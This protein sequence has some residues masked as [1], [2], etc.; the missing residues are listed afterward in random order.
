MIPELYRTMFLIRTF[1]EL[2]GRLFRQ[3]LLF[4]T[5]HACIGQEAVAAGL[6]A[7]LGPEDMVLS[8]HRG[9][10]HFLAV[11]DDL[12]GL[13]LEIMGREGGVCGGR[14]GSQHLRAPRFYSNGVQ[15]GMVPV[16]A[17][18]ALAEKLR[19]GKGLTVCFIGDGTLGQGVV[20]ETLNLASL[21]GLPLVFA[22]ENNQYAMST[23]VRDALAGSILMRGEAFGVPSA[24]C[25]GNDA[26]QVAAFANEH[27]S[28]LRECPGPMVMVFDTYRLCGHSKS[29][30]CAYRARE[31]E[32]R[33][34]RRDPLAQLE[35]RLDAGAAA[36][37]RA[38]VGAR[39]DQALARAIKAPEAC[40]SVGGHHAR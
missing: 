37:I 21:W 17:G 12:D 1:E 7:A 33:W 29:D 19:G 28:R 31:E 15:G 40:P 20:Y 3:G 5:T 10:G 16:A 30:D 6:A 18:L 11:T 25:P 26:Q 32:E 27:F 38:E 4:G 14:G 22:V 23:P 34:A 2:V 39:L 35:A 9:H 13:L 24:E 36:A 8:N